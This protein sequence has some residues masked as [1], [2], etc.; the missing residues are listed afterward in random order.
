[1]WLGACGNLIDKADGDRN[2]LHN[3]ATG[4]ESGCL[5]YDFE[6]KR[7]E[8]WNGG[9]RRRLKKPRTQPTCILEE[10]K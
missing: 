5:K 4:D 10:R 6:S 3:I 7:D 8:V 9:I 1:M 2:I